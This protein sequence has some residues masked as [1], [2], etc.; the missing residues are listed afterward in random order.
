MPHVG[1]KLQRSNGRTFEVPQDLQE[2]CRNKA[3]Y[4]FGTTK[5][6]EQRLQKLDNRRNWITYLGILVP[7]LIGGAAL[8]FGTEWL[9]LVIIPAGI[10]GCIQLALSAWSLVAKWDDKHAYALSAIQAQTSL[11]NSWDRLAKRPPTD[12]DAQVSALDAEDQRQ[13][14]AD[15]T[16]NLAPPEK[17]YAMLASLYH[18][19][20][21]CARCGRTPTS[22]KPPKCD[23]CGNF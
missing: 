6:F 21:A 10:L 16:Q 17:R 18:F 5:I 7:L 2:H 3:F 13:E 1:T 14:Q 11:F 19:G 20:K 4:A 9:P 12:L 22:L 15:L 23:T 8:S